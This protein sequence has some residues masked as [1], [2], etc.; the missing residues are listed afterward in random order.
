MVTRPAPQSPTPTPARHRTVVSTPRSARRPGRAGRDGGRRQG[1]GHRRSS[2]LTATAGKNK[3]DRQTPWQQPAAQ[4][5][6]TGPPHRAM[7]TGQHFSHPAPHRHPAR[8]TSIVSRRPYRPR[9]DTHPHGAAAP[10]RKVKRPRPA[11][12][13]PAQISWAWRSAHVLNTHGWMKPQIGLMRPWPT[14]NGGAQ[15]LPGTAVHRGDDRA[16]DLTAARSTAVRPPIPRRSAPRRRCGA[17]A[18]TENRNPFAMPGVRRRC[19]PGG[20][21][22]QARD[23][24]RIRR[25]DLEP[26]MT[27]R[28][29][30]QQPGRLGPAVAGQEHVSS[31]DTGA[32][33]GG[34]RGSRP[35][36]RSVAGTRAGDRS[37]FP[38]ARG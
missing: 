19:S 9:A 4:A 3:P 16:I 38:R 30:G 5:S 7:P 28:V 34:A 20:G 12:S 27:P 24:G 1:D 10:P 21:Q 29:R 22:T 15:V 23:V 37:S 2:G 31:R 8:G 18:P 17:R 33:S 25:D 26:S 35:P 14:P 11:S 13:W 32:D 36:L 6:P